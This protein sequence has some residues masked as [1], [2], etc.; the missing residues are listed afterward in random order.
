[1]TVTLAAITV[2]CDDAHAL[3][4]FW[5]AALDRPLAS[6]PAPSRE[7]ALIGRADH[8]ADAPP[9]WMFTRV[10]EEKTAKNRM[11][12][13]LVAEDRR[14]EIDRLVALGASRVADKDE[15]GMQWTV[16]TDPEGNEFCVAQG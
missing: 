5:S 3:A 7:F 4:R 1:M 6:E 15:W 12:V 10:P 11:H 16:L 8:G 14:A 9:S 2:D 13:D